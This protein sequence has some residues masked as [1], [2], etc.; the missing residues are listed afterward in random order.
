M[1]ARCWGCGHGGQRDGAGDVGSGH[2][3][4]H[5]VVTVVTPGAWDVGSGDAGGIGYQCASRWSRCWDVGCGHGVGMWSRWSWCWECW[6]WSR[7]WGCC[8]WHRDAHVHAGW[9]FGLW[10]RRPR[11]ISLHRLCLW[12]VTVLS[13]TWGFPSQFIES[14]KVLMA[15]PLS[16]PIRSHRKTH[17]QVTSLVRLE[18]VTS[19]SC[20]NYVLSTS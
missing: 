2:G 7:C 19:G 5:D 16:R 6:L 10:S 18:S 8:H 9:E 1:L 15:T 4:G 12:Q 13:R 20:P 11:V 3:V 14:T 17:L